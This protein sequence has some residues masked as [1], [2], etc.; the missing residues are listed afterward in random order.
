MGSISVT[1]ITARGAAEKGEGRTLISFQYADDV[2]YTQGRNAIKFGV[3][4]DRLQN[5]GWNPPRARLLPVQ[6]HH[7]WP[8]PESSFL[9]QFPSTR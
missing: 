2:T 4:W 1:G 7:D 5:N 3:N 9:R 8:A 6:L